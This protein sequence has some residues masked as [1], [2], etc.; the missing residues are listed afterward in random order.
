[1]IDVK[2]C[3]C[4]HKRKEK[5]PNVSTHCVYFLENEFG[6]I[7]YIGKSSPY[8][9]SARL[10]RHALQKY[11]QR[12]YAVS[13]ICLTSSVDATIL[14]AYL[15]AKHKPELNYDMTFEDCTIQ[16]EDLFEKRQLIYEVSDWDRELAHHEK[17]TPSRRNA[18]KTLGDYL[19]GK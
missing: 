17:Q 6:D 7:L 18:R 1:M 8:N 11:F 4:E 3:L 16:V 5:F 19:R 14:E 15:L 10:S 2:L 9:F 12:M 13:I